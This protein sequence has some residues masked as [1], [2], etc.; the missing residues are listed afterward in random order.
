MFSIL[1]ATWNNLDYLKLCIDSIRKHSQAEHEI[2][3]HVN[4]G[5]DDTLDWLRDQNIRHT[6]SSANIG[7]CLS[8]N[9]LAARA[10]GDWLICLNDD[11]V[12][13]RGWD[14]GY[15][16]AIRAANTTLA[17]FSSTLIEPRETRND[18]VIFADCGRRPGEFS[19]SKMLDCCHAEQRADKFG[20]TSQPFVIHRDWWHMVGGYSIEFGP[21][22][23]F[24]QRSGDEDVGR[25]LP[26]FPSF[27]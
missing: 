2:L 12:C 4:E 22:I 16:A 15:V 20:R 5:N 17:M 1:I 7:V 6:H 19:K 27:G 11:M 18:L 26:S 21:G 8:Y 10:S 14:T 13:C 9:H 23:E 24:G 25:G 3:V